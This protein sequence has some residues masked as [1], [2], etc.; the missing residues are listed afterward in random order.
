MTGKRKR[1]EENRRLITGKRSKRI[2]FGTFSM[3]VIPRD[4]DDGSNKNQHQ[5]QMIPGLGP[6]EFGFPNS[7]VTRLRYTQVH[8]ITST[9]GLV[10]SKVFRANGCHDPDYTNVGHQPM[11]WDQWKA[12]YDYYTV[13]GS[14]IKVT[15]RSA[16]DYGMFIGL[17]GSTTSTP[18]SAIET[19]GEQNNTVSTLI[20]NKNTNPKT[21]FM[22]YSPT[23][24]MGQSVKD[25]GSSM[26]AVG[27]DPTA[28][29]GTYYYHIYTATEDQATTSVLYAYVEIEYTIKFTEL[30][31]NSGS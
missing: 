18:S 5:A 13:L 12:I 6:L 22:T 30:S 4:N 26:T 8:A 24:N 3:E 1:S 14:K 28:G 9:S 31:K 25:D 23:E 21:L 10:A 27:A 16:S 29:E 11:Y 7:I 20:G 2:H 15:F 19:L 17:Q